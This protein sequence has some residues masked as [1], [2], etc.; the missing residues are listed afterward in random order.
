MR[1]YQVRINGG[2]VS[3]TNIHSIAF[4]QFRNTYRDNPED[5]CELVSVITET[6]MDSMDLTDF[7]SELNQEE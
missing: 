2:V 6:L 7:I 4:K 5:A 1:T 3:E